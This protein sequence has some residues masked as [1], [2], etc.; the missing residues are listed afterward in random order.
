MSKLEI[1]FNDSKS[2][3]ETL[4]NSNFHLW[5]LRKMSNKNDALRD[6]VSASCVT[7]PV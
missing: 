4:P 5:F 7:T 3:R 1:V 6:D 2:L